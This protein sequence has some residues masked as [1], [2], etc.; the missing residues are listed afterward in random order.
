MHPHVQVL[1]FGYEIIDLGGLVCGLMG[2]GLLPE[3]GGDAR[4][5]NGGPGLDPRGTYALQDAANE[6]MRLYPQNIVSIDLR[7]SMQAASGVV[8]PPFPNL[9]FFTL[10]L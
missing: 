10:P 4:C 3:C 9:D 8:E 6:L 2:L 5:M 1:I 7:G